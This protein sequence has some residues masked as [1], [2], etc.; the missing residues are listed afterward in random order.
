[1]KITPE[2]V[3]HVAVLARLRLSPEQSAKLTGQLNDILTHMEKLGQLDTS[4]VASTNHALELTGALRPDLVRPSLP[5]EQGLANAPQ[6]DGVSFIV[7]RV[8]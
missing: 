7:P 8:I 5:R 2:E 1:M 3:A 4:S 6:D